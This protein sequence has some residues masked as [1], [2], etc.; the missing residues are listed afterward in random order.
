MENLETIIEQLREKLLSGQESLI[1]TKAL[2]DLSIT[3]QT[4]VD[5]S[6][7]MFCDIFRDNTQ[8][9]FKDVFKDGPSCPG[10]PFRDRV[11]K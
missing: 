9:R 8:P 3:Y 11:Y 5:E 1:D 7:N 2:E 6:N 4:S 10:G